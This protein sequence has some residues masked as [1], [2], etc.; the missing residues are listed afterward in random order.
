[1][2]IGARSYISRQQNSLRS[3]L[4]RNISGRAGKIRQLR[5]HRLPDVLQN[6]NRQLNHTRTGRP[7]AYIAFSWLPDW[8][9][10]IRRHLKHLCCFLSVCLF[11]PPPLSLPLLSSS[12]LSLPLLYR[13]L[14]AIHPPSGLSNSSSR[15]CVSILSSFPSFASFS[16]FRYPPFINSG[17]VINIGTT[18]HLRSKQ[19]IS[20]RQRWGNTNSRAEAIHL[21]QCLCWAHWT[22]CWLVYVCVCIQPAWALGQTSRTPACFRRQT[23][24]RKDLPAVTYAGTM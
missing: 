7:A 8:L 21:R 6:K 17:R 2:S 20:W 16:S 12:S 4:Y 13:L 22:L 1:M 23:T 11:H 10:N 15:L 24:D 14:F 5:H 3:K 9:S 19:C 18:R